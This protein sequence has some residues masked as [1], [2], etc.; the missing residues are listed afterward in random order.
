M[1]PLRYTPGIDAAGDEV[2]GHAGAIRQAGEEMFTYLNQ[3]CESG[4]LRGEGIEKALRESHQRWNI[5]CDEFAAKEEQFGIAVKD[6]YANMIATDM[7]YA[8]YF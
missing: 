2:I 8:S 6:A 3:M 7:R 1:G 5:A 4:Q